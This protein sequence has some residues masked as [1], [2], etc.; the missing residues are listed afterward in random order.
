V[1]A[2]SK[3]ARKS[4][5]LSHAA[6]HRPADRFD[7]LTW[8]DVRRPD[9]ALVTKVDHET[10][11]PEDA[12]DSR[13]DWLAR[14][15]TIGRYI[16]LECLGVGGMGVIYSAWDPRLDR[17]L[18]IKV[19]RDRHGKLGS[20]RGRA[21]LLREGQALA[22]LRHPNVISVHDVGTHED[23]VFVAMEFVEGE[24][25][26]RWLLRSPRPPI[27]QLIDVFLQ[28]GRG[29]AAA[30]RAGL[31]HR[32]VKPDNVMLG[33]DGRVLVLDF[34]IA[35]EGLLGDD[36]DD[37]EQPEAPT[38]VEADPDD[39]PTAEAIAEPDEPDVPLDLHEDHAPLAQL[40]RA[41][42]VV[43]TPAYMSPEQHRGLPLDTR[44]DQFSFC[45][46]MW[47]A[48]SGDKPYGEGGRE[49]LLARMRTGQLRPFRNREVPRRIVVALRRGLAWSARDRFD[50]M[51]A[52]LEALNPRAHALERKVWSS[53]GLGAVAG[54]LAGVLLTNVAFHVR[55]PAPSTDGSADAEPEPRSRTDPQ[56]VQLRRT[57]DELELARPPGDPSVA[58]VRRELARA[59][60]ALG[61]HEAALAEY[62]RALASYEQLVNE[63]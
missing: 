40:T 13:P 15:E 61:E 21:R 46:A 4:T 58:R 8:V 1:G 50:S 20:A 26:H 34:G 53:L 62:E 59:L 43:G 18:A 31:V 57:L 5:F 41:G 36:G 47:E 51:E 54:M 2:N 11:E 6:N 19:V 14:G 28:V 38:E 30:H 27:T 10:D 22:R 37:G 44:S 25:L 45:V 9:E 12:A 24:T 56:V 42:A 16:V 32:D 17:K 3:P 35:R 49:K 55:P 48:L 63:R 23:R 60:A 29:L 39:E 33:D 52:L 7:R